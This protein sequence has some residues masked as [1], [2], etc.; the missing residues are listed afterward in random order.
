MGPFLAGMGPFLA[1]MGL[2]LASAASFPA[3]MGRFPS[4]CPIFCPQAACSTQFVQGMSLFRGEDTQN[5]VGVYAISTTRLA[6]S[7]AIVLLS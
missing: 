4:P 6:E 1:G 7:C 5:S 3:G 2:G